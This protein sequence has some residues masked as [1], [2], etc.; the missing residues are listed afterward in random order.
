MRA[1]RQRRAGAWAVR[2]LTEA[3]ARTVLVTA[4]PLI[5]AARVSRSAGQFLL[6]AAS[7]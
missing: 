2:L 7:R 5:A 3:L 1:S 6:R 4:L